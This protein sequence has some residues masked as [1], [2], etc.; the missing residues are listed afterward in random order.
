MISIFK[1]LND[2]QVIVKRGDKYFLVSQSRPELQPV[3]TLVFPCDEEGKVND[4][5]EVDGEVGSTIS[6]FLPRLLETGDFRPA[7]EI[8]S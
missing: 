8:P 2:R 1:E 3:E 5:F 7:W 4:W 6:Q